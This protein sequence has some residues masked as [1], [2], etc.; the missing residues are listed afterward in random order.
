M[1]SKRSRK[2]STRTQVRPGS[3]WGTRVVCTMASPYDPA[4][5]AKYVEHTLTEELLPER[6]EALPS[7]WRCKACKIVGAIL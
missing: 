2:S 5:K 4:L 1:A 6:P 7:Q 3:T